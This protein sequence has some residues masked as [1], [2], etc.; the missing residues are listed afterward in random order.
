MP[1]RMTVSSSEKTA[2]NP[3]SRIEKWRNHRISIPIAAKP[4][5]ASA[6]LVAG[7]ARRHRADRTAE[8][9]VDC[10]VQ[11]CRQSRFCAVPP[12]SD[13]RAATRA[14]N[15]PPAA[16]R[17]N[18]TAAICVAM[19]AR[20]R[21]QREVGQKASQRRAGGV[22][23]VQRARSG[24]RRS[25]TSLSDEM[26]NEERQRP[27]HQQRDGRQQDDGDRCAGEIRR[28]RQDVP[29]AALARVDGR[30]AETW[31]RCG[32][33]RRDAQAPC[34]PMSELASS[35]TPE[36]ATAPGCRSADPPTRRREAA[37][38]EAQHED[39]DHQR[40][41]VDRVPEHVAEHADPDDLIDQAAEA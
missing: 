28:R 3:P 23:R 36:A 38:A 20:S 12:A 9:A 11:A 2:R 41:G 22:D 13:I 1:I 35:R 18:D 34:T 4:D 31:P 7:R 21:H 15:A 29:A 40:R 39:R 5:I 30:S 6:R 19:K 16:T 14:R 27:T 26:T 37:G 17:L 33:Q 25:S 32:K 8:S 24:G 10:P